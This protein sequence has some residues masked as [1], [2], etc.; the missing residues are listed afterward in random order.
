MIRQKLMIKILTKEQMRNFTTPRH[1]S[2]KISK[3]NG[4]GIWFEHCREVKGFDDRKILYI[5]FEKSFWVQN[6]SNFGYMLTKKEYIRA[7]KENK[8][9]GELKCKKKRYF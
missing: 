6:F 9:K 7:L 3:V 8:T 1:T 5:P 2:L 4:N